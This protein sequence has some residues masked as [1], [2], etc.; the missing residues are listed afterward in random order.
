VTVSKAVK[1]LKDQGILQRFTKREL[2]IADFPG[3]CRLSEGT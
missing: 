2:A 3:L 1:R